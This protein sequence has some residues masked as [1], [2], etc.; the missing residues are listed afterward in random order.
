MSFTVGSKSMLAKLMATENLTVVHK[1]MET[2]MI[3]IKSRTIY[4]PVWQNM[5]GQLYDLLTG[6]EVGH[7]LFTPVEGLHTTMTAPNRGKHFKAFLNVVEDA[8]IEKKIQRRYP[9]LR[10]SFYKAYTELLE[11]DFFGLKGRNINNL[12][13]IDR[14]NI[15][16]KT[17]YRLDIEFNAT[18]QGFVERVKNM[19]TWE[20]AVQLAEEIYGYSKVEQSRK[21]KEQPQ[22]GVDNNKPNTDE[23]KQSGDPETQ[24]A[25]GFADETEESGESDIS[26]SPDVDEAEDADE[27]GENGNSKKDAKGD[28]GDEANSSTDGEKE[29][30]ASSGE[31]FDFEPKCETD[32]AFRANEQTLV[33]TG[34][35]NPHYSNIP[36]PNLKRI[37]T[38]A[39][40]V[41]G[42]MSKHF[43]DNI[44]RY[45]N[46][47]DPFVSKQL[48]ETMAQEWVNQ[49]KKGNER[50]VSML[51]KEFE[52]RK[53]AKSYSK[54]KIADTGDIDVNK[55][56]QYRFEDNMFRKL[57]MTPKGKSHG[58][59]LLLDCSG[60]MQ[61]NMAGS[62]EQILVLSM[63]CRKVNIPFEVYG[64]GNSGVVDIMDLEYQGI[65]PRHAD[66][67]FDIQDGDMVMGNI[68]LRQYLHSGM[69]SREFNQALRNLVLLRQT[70]L[71]GRAGPLARP[72]SEQLSYTPLIEAIVVTADIMKEFKARTKVDLTSL[73]VVHDGDADTVSHTNRVRQDGSVRSDYF[74]A[75]S[76]DVH[77][78]HKRNKYYKKIAAMGKGHRYNVHPNKVLLEN[79]LEWF[80]E[81][82]GSKVI[83]FFIVTP[84]KGEIRK[85]LREKYHYDDGTV[86]NQSQFSWEEEKHK[87]DVL[88]EKFRKENFLQSSNTGYDDFFFLMGGQELLT[89]E[90]KLEVN[91]PITNKK[92]LNAFI[93]MNKKRA[94]SRV[95]VNR[96]IQKI[97]A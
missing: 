15:Y 73:V 80:R 93:K 30:Q 85:A 78:T 20:Q 64:F 32:D 41:H 36:T 5:S 97:A 12:P 55:L 92:L 61:R 52:M 46:C 33:N 25:D 8:R 91:G 96:F 84:T 45:G 62:I 42:L 35:A 39:H 10:N 1:Q 88:I 7:A 86:I 19:E 4:L 76:S 50:Y 66:K 6:H 9:G 79:I 60:S 48:N 67:S 77:L 82:T 49:F 83:G 27:D 28:A 23:A 87:L 70:Y 63:F 3:D 90:E 34:A 71:N 31:D 11:R 53:A 59:V 51:A 17:Q 38:P 54:A 47:K 68:S 16:T 43:S 22:S 21:E 37:V 58:L 24:I 69:N 13:F 26:D 94:V 72:M 29:S 89:D 75:I 57:L 14:L 40:V 95:L 74:N 18:E 44:N 65:N 81:V 56:A 2:A